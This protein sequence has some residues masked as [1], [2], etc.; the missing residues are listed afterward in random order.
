MLSMFNVL[1]FSKELTTGKTEVKACF[2]LKTTS[3]IKEI[4]G[5]FSTEQAA[6][7]WLRK[8]KC[9][10]FLVKIENYIVHK[11]HIIDNAPYSH[12]SHTPKK[13]ALAECLEY[14]R[15]AA[16]KQDLREACKWAILRQSQL[17]SIL[18][19]QT[20]TSYLSSKKD[21]EQIL[22]FAKEHAQG[23]ILREAC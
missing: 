8:E 3:E 5:L 9:G 2:Q 13:Q 11:K 17:E 12:K 22:E 23:A 20:N 10:Y 16:E 7:N 14:L 21:L 18:P 1:K 6:K 15:Y 19:A 4:G